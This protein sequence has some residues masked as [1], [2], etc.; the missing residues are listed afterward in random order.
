M[1]LATVLTALAIVAGT[2]A[3]AV[4]CAF[5][6]SLLDP[7]QRDGREAAL[8][9]A[10]PGR[11]ECGACGYDSCELLAKA[12]ASKATATAMSATSATS[13][14]E[15]AMTAVS[16]A[17]PAG[18]VKTARRLAKIMGTDSTPPEIYKRH[19]ARS[20]CPP[21]CAK[22]GRVYEY[23]G[24]PSCVL[25]AYLPSGGAK[26]CKYACYGL[27]DCVRAC[28]FAAISTESGVAVVDENLCTAC[29][30]CVG[31]CPQKLLSIA[32]YDSQE[33]IACP[34]PKKGRTM[35]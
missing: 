15:A 8:L 17:C 16:P 12:L 23:R 21:T 29:G 13:H 24:L 35:M 19:I 4:L 32:P 28:R 30:L 25:Q 5:L 27:G 22:A 18:G 11:S 14:A 2:A 7:G 3:V 10:L 31:K 6:S 34:A 20:A 1:T 26:S 9:A 33:E